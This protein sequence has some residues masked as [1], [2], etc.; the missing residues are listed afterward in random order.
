MARHKH[1]YRAS[2]K[3]SKRGRRTKI[4]KLEDIYPIGSGI[5]GEAL[6][7]RETVSLYTA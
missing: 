5:P 2:N 6:K 7:K 1:R 4:V 3:K